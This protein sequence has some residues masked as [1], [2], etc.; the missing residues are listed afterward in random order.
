[1]TEP[2]QPPVIHKESIPAN[3]NGSAN[4]PALSAQD[5]SQAETDEETLRQMTGAPNLNQPL[6]SKDAFAD[7]DIKSSRP[8]WKLPGPKLTLIAVAL[9]PV[10]GVAGYFIAGGRSPQQQT[11]VPTEPKTSEKPDETEENSELQQAEQEIASLKS[12]IALDDQAYVQNVQGS[13]EPTPSSLTTSSQPSDTVTTPSP[14]PQA[15][16]VTTRSSPPPTVNYSPP[17]PPIQPSFTAASSSAPFPESFVDID[18]VE[19]WRQ[20]ARLGSYGN[21]DSGRETQQ[22]DGDLAVASSSDPPSS[23]GMTASSAVPVAYFAATSATVPT[24]AS[25]DFQ[26]EVSMEQQPS[27]ETREDSVGKPEEDP[28]SFANSPNTDEPEILEEAESRI[29]E[30]QGFGTISAMQS[31]VAGSHAA[32]EL[33][34]PVVIDNEGVG[35]L[36]MVVLAESLTDNSSQ[37]VIPAGALLTVQ[38]D[39]VSENGLVQLSAT[40]AIWEEQGFQ[41]ELVLP[42]QTILIRGDSGNPLIAESYGDIGGD[43]AAMD[44]G[45]FALGA[46]RR[47][48]ELYTRSDS[49]VQTGDGTTVITE[50]NP[51]PNILAG[52]LEGGSEAI[53]DAISDRNQRAIEK[54]Q[55]RP[56]VP[57]IPA[58]SSVQVFVN[59]SMQ[60]PSSF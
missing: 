45:Q 14:E 48:G 26:S 51:A 36:F 13:Q 34:T 42:N 31:L 40:E 55:E 33:V 18:P 12:Q 39:R 29:L 43:V 58:G 10:F 47:V 21:I 6:V 17:P 27:E 54:L 22:V 53:L 25:I 35:D 16:S 5:E 50:S 44:M 52:A 19:Q 56:R 15:V 46:I 2:N 38:V 4:K 7:V 1:M 20:L 59:Q 57:H 9:V 24:Y 32:G 49:R 41:R 3:S 60:I 8:I 23:E 37:T 28:D 30:E 11:A